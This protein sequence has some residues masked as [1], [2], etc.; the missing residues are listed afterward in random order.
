MNGEELLV[1]LLGFPFV[2][3]EDRSPSLVSFKD[4]PNKIAKGKRILL[5]FKCSIWGLLCVILTTITALYSRV[6]NI[7]SRRSCKFSD[8][9]SLNNAIH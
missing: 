5:L 7:E 6:P 3:A 2:L 9:F 1:Y 8:Y 4:E